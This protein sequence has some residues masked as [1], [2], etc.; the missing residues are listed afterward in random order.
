MEDAEALKKEF[1]DHLM[2]DSVQITDLPPAIIVHV[3]PGVV[4]ASFFIE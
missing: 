2:I 4:A 1:E 3:G